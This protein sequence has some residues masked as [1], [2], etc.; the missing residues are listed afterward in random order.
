MRKAEGKEFGLWLDH[1]GNVLLFRDD[2]LR[3]YAEGVTELDEG[4]LEGKVRR[5]ITKKEREEIRCSCGYLCMPWD[6]KCPGCGKER[7]RRSGVEVIPGVMHE[8]TGGAASK[9]PDW[10]QN[11]GSVWSQLCTYAERKY[12]G[13][14]DQ[15]KKFALAKYKAFYGSWPGR[16]YAP[17]EQVSVDLQKRLKHEAIKFAKGAARKAA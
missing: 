16:D 11:R 12:N 15:A 13:N 5:E 8:V 9:L 3:I 10:M 1:S 14:A 17:T 4:R 2:E 6:K 7:K